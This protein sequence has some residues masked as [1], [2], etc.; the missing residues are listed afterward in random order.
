MQLRGLAP[1]TQQSY[2]RAV[3]Q[4]AKHYAKSPDR[5]TTEEL[6][7]YFLYLHNQKHVARNTSTQALCAI[8]FFYQTTL[9]WDWP[10][11]EFFRPPK[12]HKLPVVLNPDEVWR[13][14]DQQLVPCYQALTE[15]GAPSLRKLL[16]LTKDADASV[17][18]EAATFSLKRGERIDQIEQDDGHA[19]DHESPVE[20][21]G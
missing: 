17:R 14:L 12:E 2:I 5:I 11:L 13:I 19:D 16:A 15:R 3:E 18:L 8:K 6:R 20:R 4:L 7:Q 21:L 1:R 10:I 9:K